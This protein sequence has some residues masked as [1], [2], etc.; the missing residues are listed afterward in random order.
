MIIEKV[1]IENF[2]AFHNVSVNLGQRLTVVAGRNGTQK[3]T[4]LGILSQPFSLSQGS[5]K[6]Q[7]TID[8]YDFKSQFKEKFKVSEKDIDQEY[9]WILSV[10]PDVYESGRYAVKS[11]K[12]K[13][14]TKTTI[15]FWS[16]MPHTKGNGYIQ[17]PV[18]YLSL[19]RV[20]PIGES[21]KTEDM[22]IE[23]SSYE[24][25]YCIENYRSILSAIQ[26]SHNG[27]S[28]S[29]KKDTSGLV[30]AGVDDEYH[31]VFTNSAGENNIL[32]IIFAVLSFDRLK[33]NFQKE[34]KGGMLLIDEIESTLFER[35]QIELINFL[36]K[37]SKRLGLQVI[38][39]SH[40][41]IVIS[42]IYELMKSQGE[43]DKSLYSIVWLNPVYNDVTEM[44]DIGAFNVL[45]NGDYYRCLSSVNLKLPDLQKKVKLYCEDKL[46]TEFIDF[47]LKNKMKFDRV[48]NIEFNEFNLGWK[49]YIQLVRKNIDE[50]IRNIVLLDH[51]VEGSMSN[52]DRNT[53][54]NYKNIIFSPITV[55]R[56]IFLYLYNRK[57]F[58]KFL[59]LNIVPDYYSYEI[60]FAGSYSRGVE[61]LK[62]IDYKNWYTKLSKMLQ[63][64]IVKVFGLW[65]DDNADAVNKFALDFVVSYNK[66][67]SNSP[68]SELKLVGL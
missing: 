60:C 26:T 43:N 35:A 50:F 68:I 20:A 4:L 6:G 67:V 16:D 21:K 31:D 8:G 38:F 15:R 34:Y 9:R 51:D 41:Q 30:Y 59:K 56:D 66:V 33:R 13:C 40:S 46:A 28:F 55:E 19:K 1:C 49:N 42:R 37:E 32:K 11:L 57:N 7:K 53:V 22:A 62:T 36:N 5:L 65:C 54:E 2:R 17:V 44:Y 10:N 23:L 25:R 52:E 45:N 48:P 3:T 29:L 63:D 18:Y 24:K 64:D 58:E 47:I 61:F 12:R 39:T 14:R 27:E